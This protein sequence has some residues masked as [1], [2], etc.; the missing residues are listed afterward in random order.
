MQLTHCR[1]K[2]CSQLDFDQI[3][4]LITDPARPLEM[5]FVCLYEV[6]PPMQ[7]PSRAVWKDLSIDLSRL[8][9]GHRVQLYG[10]ALPKPLGESAAGRRRLIQS[11]SACCG[12]PCVAPMRAP[13]CLEED[14]ICH[15]MACAC[16]RGFVGG[17]GAQVFCVSRTRGVN[18]C[19]N[20]S[21]SRVARSG[22]CSE[23]LRRCA[24]KHSTI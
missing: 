21:P 3:I 10:G 16:R 11:S 19:S 6:R 24:A 22:R 23:Q 12:V 17:W 7:F 1:G 2:D 8:G 9:I 20:P 18:H 13:V 14:T 5:T 4:L 15:A